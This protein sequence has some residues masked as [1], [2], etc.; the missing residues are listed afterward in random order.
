MIQGVRETPFMLPSLLELCEAVYT[1]L[2]RMSLKEVTVSKPVQGHQGW[3]Q[4]GEKKDLQKLGPQTGSVQELNGR[5]VQA[6]VTT[7][8]KSK[9]TSFQAEIV[10]LLQNDP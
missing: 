4:A 5:N 1:L 8:A 2:G 3:R 9:G 10:V 7:R 6:A